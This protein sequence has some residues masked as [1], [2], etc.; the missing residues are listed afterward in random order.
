M[1][2]GGANDPVTATTGTKRHRVRGNP[3]DVAVIDTGD[4]VNNVEKTLTVKTHTSRLERN[5]LN[6]GRRRD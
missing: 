2:D 1:I 4:T 6:R 5:T 3:G